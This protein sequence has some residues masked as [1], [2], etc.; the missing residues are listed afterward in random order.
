METETLWFNILP[1]YYFLCGIGA[2]VLFFKMQQG[3]GKAIF[4]VISYINPEW[5]N[6]VTGRLFEAFMF[7][8][9]GAVVGTIIAQPVNPQQAIAAGLGWTGLIG[10]FSK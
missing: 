8:A 4:S 1:A 9:L 2:L 6:S 3:R 10:T 7:A 5:G